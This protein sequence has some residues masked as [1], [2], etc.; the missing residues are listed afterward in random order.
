MRTVESTNRCPL[1][2]DAAGDAKSPGPAFQ[3]RASGMRNEICCEPGGL[4]AIY[5]PDVNLA[6]WQ[7]ELTPVLMQAVRQL[8]ETTRFSS[9]SA[10]VSAGSVS[11]LLRARLPD[12]DGKQVV[13]DDAAFLVD[14][15][16]CLFDL[17]QT[18]FRMTVLDR[19]MCPRFHVDHVPCRLVTTYAGSAMEWLP[20]DFVDR[21]RL[22]LGNN[23]LPDHISGIY[24]NPADINQLALGDVALLKGEK[25]LGNEGA[26]LVHRSPDAGC[27]GKRLLLTLDFA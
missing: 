12:C 19:V 2:Q 27:N 7:R 1:L 10:V 4:S 23:G 9:I 20:N 22:G 24:Q 26:G 5:A 8:V 16:T 18:G 25:W 21:R 13:I 14:L 3:P 11:E 17:P 6:V 15:F